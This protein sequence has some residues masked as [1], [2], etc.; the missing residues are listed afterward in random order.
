[1][2]VCMFVS[3]ACVLSTTYVV[4]TAVRTRGCYGLQVAVLLDP[5]MVQASW[6]ETIGEDTKTLGIHDVLVNHPV[7]MVRYQLISDI[8]PKGLW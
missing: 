1:M 5:A 3:Y 8:I 6:S 7:D 4:M 2:Y